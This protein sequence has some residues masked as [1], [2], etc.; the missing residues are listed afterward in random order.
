VCLITIVVQKLGI[1]KILVPTLAILQR[2]LPTY[3]LVS[4]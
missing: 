3:L 1:R 2:K 4:D